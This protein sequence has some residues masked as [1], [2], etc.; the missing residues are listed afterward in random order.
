MISPYVNVREDKKA[1]MEMGRNAEDILA[2][3]VCKHFPE[4][5]LSVVENPE[6]KRNPRTLD[7]LMSLGK[8]GPF[9]LNGKR[10]YGD[11]KCQF[12]PF[13]KPASSALKSLAWINENPEVKNFFESLRQPN[14]VP[15]P[16]TNPDKVR[17][18]WNK[19]DPTFMMSFN[20]KC[21]LHYSDDDVIVCY[22]HWDDT[23]MFGVKVTD[24]LSSVYMSKMKRVRMQIDELP[25]WHAYINRRTT[26][27]K[28][29]VLNEDRHSGS[30]YLID[31]RKMTFVGKIPRELFPQKT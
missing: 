10:F 30:S 12:T 4:T 27:P 26:D 8:V 15:L 1:S 28:S 5:F 22:I 21:M 3:A 9:D 11:A 13:F 31:V 25:L 19:I 14:G 17:E 29:I 18:N 16:L 2:K 6:K 7:Y 24:Q 23:S 20:L